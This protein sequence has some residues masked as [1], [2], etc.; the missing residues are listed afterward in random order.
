MTATPRNRLIPVVNTGL[1]PWASKNYDLSLESYSIKGAY[2]RYPIS[3]EYRFTRSL[4]LYGSF[5]DF[6]TKGLNP[7]Q[8]RYASPDTPDYA[9][10]NRIQEWGITVTAGI[11]DEF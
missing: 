7:V 5:G 4:G 6:D 11:K 3:G 1:T 8:R 2:R 9:I 10:Y